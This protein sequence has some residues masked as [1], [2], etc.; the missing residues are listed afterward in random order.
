MPVEELDRSHSYQET[1]QPQSENNR[2][3]IF[4]SEMLGAQKHVHAWL[5]QESQ[6]EVPYY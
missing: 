1:Q 3:E 5:Q 4:Q 6:E 2:Q